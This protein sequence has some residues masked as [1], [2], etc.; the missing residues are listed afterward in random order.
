M[1]RFPIHAELMMLTCKQYESTFTIEQAEIE[2]DDEGF[3]FYCPDCQHRNVLMTIEIPGEPPA[4][5]QF[6]S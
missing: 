6:D 2:I 5:V 3:C 4:V 1:L